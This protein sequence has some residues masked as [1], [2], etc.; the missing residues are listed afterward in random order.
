MA[1]D[2]EILQEVRRYGSAAEIAQSLVQLANENGGK[3]N[4]TVVVANV[5]PYLPRMIY[6]RIRAIL[7]RGHITPG[8]VAFFILWTLVCLSGGLPDCESNA[9]SPSRSRDKTRSCSSSNQP[10]RLSFSSKTSSP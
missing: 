5:S 6:L 10:L 4:I 8:L 7:R 1:S 9:C 3:D 2:K